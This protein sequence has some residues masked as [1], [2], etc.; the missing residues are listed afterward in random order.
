MGAIK[1]WLAKKAALA[2]LCSPLGILTVI[3]V[4]AVVLLWVNTDSDKPE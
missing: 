2:Y 1:L 3:V 4:V